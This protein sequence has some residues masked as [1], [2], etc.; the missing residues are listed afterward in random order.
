MMLPFVSGIYA[1]RNLVTGKIYVGSAV[2]M[3]KRVYEHRRLLMLGTHGNRLLQRAWTKYGSD[4]F[5][6]EVLETVPNA[7]QLVAREQHY[8][9]ALQAADRKHG[10][11][12]APRAGNTL[13]V[14]CS[15]ATRLKIGAANRGKVRN[16]A[17]RERHRQI[18]Q[19]PE[20]KERRSRWTRSIDARSAISR[21]KGGT[22]RVLSP[23]DCR[24]AVSLYETGEWSMKKLAARF[25]VSYT[26]MNA[27][28][29]GAG[30]KFGDVLLPLPGAQAG[31]E[32][33]QV[34]RKIANT[35]R[36]L[37]DQQ[38]ADIRSAYAVGIMDQYALAQRYGVSQ[39]TISRVVRGVLLAYRMDTVAY[40]DPV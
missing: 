31:S 32:P 13:G 30:P 16:A 40:S 12:I 18:A 20:I 4:A 39:A 21:T 23:D 1:I 8:L 3:G 6:F 36:R 29:R 38:V 34:S 28:L 35:L 10:Y 5:Q 37:D 14:T 2:V 17:V 15:T 11:N 33:E 9:D 24:I 26:A 27:V 19:L 22:G 7:K 25:G